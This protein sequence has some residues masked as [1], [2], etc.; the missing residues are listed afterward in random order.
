MQ[1]GVPDCGQ[2]IKIQIVVFHTGTLNRGHATAVQARIPVEH[3]HTHTRARITA[4]FP[5]LPG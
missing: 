2:H 3:A 1:F 4:I 5:G